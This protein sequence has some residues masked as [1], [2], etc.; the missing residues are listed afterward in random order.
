MLDSPAMRE[1]LFTMRMSDEESGRLDAVARHYALNGAG[2]IRMLVKREYDA[3][4][5]SSADPSGKPSTK[6]SVKKRSK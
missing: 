3:I 4:A 1:R 6:A 5:S 2:V